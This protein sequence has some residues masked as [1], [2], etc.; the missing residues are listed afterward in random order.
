VSTLAEPVTTV[1]VVLL[2]GSDALRTQMRSALTEL[3][4]ELLHEGD[5]ANADCARIIALG[6]RVVLVN[7]EA[8]SE[9]A[10]D[11]L[12][13]LFAEPGINVVFNEAEA[14]SQLS[15][16]DLARWAR[17]LAA[18]VLGHRR[19]VPPP[20]AGA[21]ILPD[22][23]L[24]PEPGA[25]L[26][27][28]EEVGDIALDSFAAE[29]ADSQAG[30]PSSP[31]LEISEAL[32]GLLEDV[33]GP[34]DRRESMA[35]PEPV[36]QAEPALQGETELLADAELQVD[37]ELQTEAELEPEPE[38]VL[39]PEPESASAFTLEL[40][41]PE[42]TDALPDPPPVALDRILHGGPIDPGSDDTTIDVA[43][44]R[45]VHG[46]VAADDDFALDL[47]E[48][49]QSLSGLDSPSI[50]L[51]ADIGTGAADSAPAGRFTDA[52]DDNHGEFGLDLDFDQRDGPL[53]VA[54]D[55]T[56]FDLSQDADVAALEAQLDSLA[57]Q[58]PARGDH[59]L[60]PGFDLSASS[61]ALAGPAPIDEPA[62]DA[63]DADDGGREPT[64]AAAAVEQRPTRDM[65]AISLAADALSLAPIDDGDA[66]GAVPAADGDR[67]P[68]VIVAETARAAS[69]S[70]SA[71]FSGS[72]LS[73]A[74]LDGGDEAQTDSAIATA[75]AAGNDAGSALPVAGGPAIPRVIVLGASI[76]GP[77][78]LRTF[79]AHLPADFPALLL[80]CQHLD[81]GFFGRLAQQL[82]KI[83]KLPVRVV[84]ADGAPVHAGEI[85]VVPSSHRFVFDEDGRIELREHT[86]PPRYKP[87]I[88]DLMRDVADRFGERAT[89]IVFSGMAGDAVEGA[90]HLTGRGGEVW[91]QS[92]ESCVVSSMVDGAR[93]RGVVEFLGTPRELAEQCVKRYGRREQPA[94][95]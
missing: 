26:T 22:R 51:A 54:D 67:Q 61:L 50:D 40:E 89:A 12:D 47:G 2:G 48:I 55:D 77:D 44:D 25:P 18:K 85:V 15:G 46:G 31:R 91:A 10:L 17:H 49:E 39:Q 71:D 24:H 14:S 9:D 72:S 64:A 36:A 33:A 95:T 56:E 34:G 59:D 76:G 11:G 45:D 20:P 90:V 78:A 73:L 3:G 68:T 93:A 37:P 8:G 86:D 28:A 6:P 13:A 63:S 16:W 70:P 58:P 74:P 81:N 60:D 83:S 84:E 52:L 1:P 88:D 43:V 94:S 65:A 7:L 82:Q 38:S 29:A 87:C 66:D 57:A 19:T 75:P 42:D 69:A 79:L 30:V 80:L 21:E 5:I 41:P 4:A 92:P 35:D 23:T 27:P 32:A 53:P 62:G